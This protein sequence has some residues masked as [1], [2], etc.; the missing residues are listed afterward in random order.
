MILKE[1]RDGVAKPY[2]FSGMQKIVHT[3]RDILG[4]PATFT[5]DAC[6]HGG[7]TELEEAERTD[8][9]GRALSAHKSQRADEGY[10]KRTME[11]ALS[12]TRKRHAHKL[13]NTAG[14]EFRNGARNA[15]RNDRESNDESV[16]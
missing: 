11:R 15:F 9:Q 14:T 4:L 1:S 16:A 13:A 10:A 5:L 12:A 6:R 7:M 2:S 8:G 3:M